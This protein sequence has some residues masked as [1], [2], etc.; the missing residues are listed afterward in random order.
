MVAIIVWVLSTGF[1][2]NYFGLSFVGAYNKEDN[3][4]L[5]LINTEIVEKYILNNQGLCIANMLYWYGTTKV[6]TQ[7]NSEKFE[8][9]MLIENVKRNVDE[10]LK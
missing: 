4:D 1:I 9:F 2:F 6:Y 10:L 5:F 3:I 8:Q 7:F